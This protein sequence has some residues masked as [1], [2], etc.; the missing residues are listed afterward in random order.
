MLSFMLLFMTLLPF[1]RL[2]VIHA[3]V[4]VDSDIVGIVALFVV[5]VCA[6][7]VFDC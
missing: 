5:V 1:V 2:V 3:R 6:Y 7:C 4:V